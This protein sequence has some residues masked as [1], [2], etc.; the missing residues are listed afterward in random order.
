MPGVQYVSYNEVVEALRSHIDQRERATAAWRHGTDTLGGL[1]W[2]DAKSYH[3]NTFE[4]P[5]MGRKES[6][7]DGEV[8]CVDP[9]MASTSGWLAL[10]G[11]YDGVLRV[12]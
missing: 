8:W 5:G 9:E 2:L 7:A 11:F 3:Q 4:P 12:K 1:V 6:L 10:C